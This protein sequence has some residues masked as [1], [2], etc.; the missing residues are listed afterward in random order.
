[1]DWNVDQYTS[2]HLSA[3]ELKFSVMSD[4]LMIPNPCLSFQVTQILIKYMYMTIYTFY[5]L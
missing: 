5:T 2:I 1:M 4:A 3:T